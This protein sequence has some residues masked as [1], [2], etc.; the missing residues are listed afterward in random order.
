MPKWMSRLVIIS[1][2]IPLVGMG[3]LEIQ[4]EDKSLTA[5]VP[6]VLVAALAVA[7][8]LAVYGARDRFGPVTAESYWPKTRLGIWTYVAALFLLPATL[9]IVAVI[10]I[11]T[12]QLLLAGVLL[13]MTITPVVLRVAQLA[14][15]R[16][17][18][19]ER[20]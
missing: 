12:N 10:S 20:R 13:A 19:S 7:V 9:L 15:I 5:L 16:R 17:M 18:R 1:P 2:A 8:I 6:F 11:F 14:A 3:L 4:R